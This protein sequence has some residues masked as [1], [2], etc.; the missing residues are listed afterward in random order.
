MG[1]T[2]NNQNGS[3]IIEFEVEFP[4]SLTSEKIEKNKKY[5]IIY[6]DDLDKMFDLTNKK[7][8]KKRKI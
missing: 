5:F 2:R 7:K 3:L 4:N 6:M 8:K 1:M